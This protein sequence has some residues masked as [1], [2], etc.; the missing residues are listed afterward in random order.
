MSGSDF[1]R[2]ALITESCLKICVAMQGTDDQVLKAVLGDRESMGNLAHSFA[3]EAQ[4]MIVHL[5][6]CRLMQDI[7][8]HMGRN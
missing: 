3:Y 7:D 6:E 2:Q 8:A 4:A 1:T 5:Q